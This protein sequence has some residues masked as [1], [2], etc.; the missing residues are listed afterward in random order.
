MLD[1]NARQNLA[2]FCQTWAEPQVH[3][4]MDEC[5][6]T[7]LQAHRL[8]CLDATALKL[9]KYGGIS[10]LCRAR[11]RLPKKAGSLTPASA[12]G[13]KLIDRLQKAGI[14]FRIVE[15]A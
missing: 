13:N 5:I 6:D 12:M 1:G 4:L 15:Q 7:L 11:D 3:Q 10:A 2:T 14:D 9:S 8:G